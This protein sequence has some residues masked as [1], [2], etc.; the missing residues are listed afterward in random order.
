M[1]AIIFSLLEPTSYY[2]VGSKRLFNRDVFLKILMSVALILDVS[3][4]VF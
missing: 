1:F 3:L 2:D 4:H